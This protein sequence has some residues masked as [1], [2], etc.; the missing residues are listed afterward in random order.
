MPLP[1]Q[2]VLTGPRP[3]PAVIA[4]AIVLLFLAPVARAQ[5][6]EPRL[7][8]PLPVGINILVA[9]YT[10][11]SGDVLVDGA[12]PITD[13]RVSTNSAT[14]AYARSFSLAGRTAQLQAA[15]PFVV[16][17]A[18]AIV[19]GQDTSRQITGLADPFLRLAV[20]LKGGPARRRSQL[21]G[22]HFGT[23]IGASLTA[24]LPLGQYDDDRIL[25]IGANRWTI[26]PE[27]AIVQSLGRG[28]A[29]EAYASVSLFSNNTEYLVT[30]TATQKPL[31]ALQ[32][33]L[34]HILGRRGWLALD[35][36][37]VSG[38]ETSVDGV[39][40]ST[41]QRNVRLGAT[42]VYTVSGGHGLRAAVSTGF[43]TR[44][45]GDFTVFSVGYSYAWGG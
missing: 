20:N 16:A 14:L 10:N 31:F 15:A 25:N 35:G 23:I 12:L 32:G 27:V 44:L 39:V 6:L 13:F 1:R 3:G 5:S 41:F 37:L 8:F 17:R 40:R 38:G 30:S 9:S 26:K 19:A 45:G 22:V 42:G 34:I 4:L 29:V 33:H 21:A 18:R 7:Y 2:D 36:T 28:W 43:Y 11:S 24:A